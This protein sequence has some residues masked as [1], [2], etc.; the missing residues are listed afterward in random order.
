VLG[1]MR[2]FRAIDKKTSRAVAALPVPSHP[3]EDTASTGNYFLEMVRKY[4]SEKY[5]DNE[6]YNG[7][8]II[9]TTFDRAGQAAA[10]AAVAKQI[11]SLQ[12]RLNRIFL[13]STRA[14]KRYKMPRDSFLAHFDSLYA[15]R[16]D[17]YAKLPDSFKLRQAQMA[18]VALDAATGGILT[19]IGG[20]NFEESKFNRVRQ[21]LRQPGSAF[22]PIVYAAAMD[23]GFSPASVVLDQPI[24]LQTPTGEWRPENYDH[25]FNGPTTIRRA[26]GLSINIV[27]IQVLMKVG[28]EIVVDL[29]RRMGFTHDI[30]PIPSLAIGSCEVTPMEMVSAYQIFANKGVAVAPYFIGKITDRSGRVLEE[31]T[32]AEHEVLSERTAYLMC[33]LLQ[34][35]VC[36]GTASMIPSLGFTRP[37][38]GKTGTTNDYSDAW[39]VGFSPQV[40]CCVWAGVDERRSL[41]AGVSG[42]IAAVPV[43]VPT[44][45]AL[46]KDLPVKYFGMAD[47]IKTEK[48]CNESHLIATRS[49]PKVKPD[50]FFRETVVDTCTMH[51]PGRKVN[52]SRT[53]MFGAGAAS[54]KNKVVKKKKN[55]F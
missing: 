3:F 37:A 29:A 10:E 13:D 19:V 51:G 15:L 1:A 47:G 46:H 25:V 31:H 44:M 41:G 34:T 53:D 38:G 26:L 52:K 54:V 18:V 42:S 16:A 17:E 20:R 27:A 35:V 23:N 2:E 36:C 32:H 33:S 5:G 9:H 39:F 30:Q 28:P 49:C 14:F 48:L 40:V 45:V 4:V 11:A 55:Q 21:A 22:K 6:L 43:W 7:G 8:L 12:R 24:T 50:W